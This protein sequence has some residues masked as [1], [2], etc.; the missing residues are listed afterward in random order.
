[1]LR[2]LVVLAVTM[3]E[4]HP[5]WTREQL[6]MLE[7]LEQLYDSRPELWERFIPPSILPTIVNLLRDI[8]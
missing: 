7:R 5:I 6:D 4:L 8:I 1:M 3:Q 2:L